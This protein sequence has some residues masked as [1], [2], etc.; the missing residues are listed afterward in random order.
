VSV[1][2][3]FVTHKNANDDALVDFIEGLLESVTLRV[4]A[5]YGRVAAARER[6]G[7]LGYRIA[8]KEERERGM[9]CVTG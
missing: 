3:S 1:V 2:T 5:A 9:V 4:R 6:G 8:V 7:I